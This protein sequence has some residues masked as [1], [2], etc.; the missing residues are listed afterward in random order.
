MNWEGRNVTCCCVDS[1]G[2]DDGTLTIKDKVLKLKEKITGVLWVLDNLWVVE[3]SGTISI[4]KN[5]EIVQTLQIP[6]QKDQNLNLKAYRLGKCMLQ[7]ATVV[8]ISGEDG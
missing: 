4:L 1:V 7:S 8:V 6:K 2:Y 3:V 5:L